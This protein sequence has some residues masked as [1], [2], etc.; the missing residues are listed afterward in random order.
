MIQTT[1]EELRKKSIDTSGHNLYLVKD[2]ENTVLYI[3]QSKNVAT[4]IQSHIA[5]RDNVTGS[6]LGRAICEKRPKSDNWPV[7]LYTFDDCSALIKKYFPQINIGGKEY[8]RCAED[9]LIHEYNPVYNR[10]ANNSYPLHRD[11]GSGFLERRAREREEERNRVEQEQVE[12][13]AYLVNSVC[14]ICGEHDT[15]ID[16]HGEKVGVL[17]DSHGFKLI[18]HECA[19]LINI[20]R[21]LK[22]NPE[23]ARKV[24]KALADNSRVNPND[25]SSNYLPRF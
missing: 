4:R 6:L 5:S 20:M 12:R 3:G 19:D 17:E 24:E 23:R 16:A 14:D 13:R 22:K 21:I 18:C 2:H 11:A 7:T 15:W 25:S 8:R 9:A 10:I 1:I